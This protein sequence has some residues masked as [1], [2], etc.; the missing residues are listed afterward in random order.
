MTAL[1]SR[2]AAAAAKYCSCSGPDSSQPA[3]EQTWKA[4]GNDGQKAQHRHRASSP[5][6]PPLW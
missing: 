1:T 3:R 6:K 5:R 4:E 2:S